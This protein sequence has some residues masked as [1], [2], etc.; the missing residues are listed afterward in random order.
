MRAL[1]NLLLAPFAM[2]LAPEPAILAEERPDFIPP[3]PGGCDEHGN[4][5]DPV[6]WEA[7]WRERN[8]GLK[9]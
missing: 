2:W 5:V 1:I 4:Y 8:K 6:E 9:S 3:P 7:W